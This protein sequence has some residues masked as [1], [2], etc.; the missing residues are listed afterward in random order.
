[1]M[2]LQEP[3]RSQLEAFLNY[4]TLER[5]FSGNTR[6]SYLNDLGRYL[7]WLQDAGVT[8]PEVVPGD[9]RKFIQELHDI[10]LEASSVARNV[11][12]I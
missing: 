5:N 10:G 11:S 8:P 1:M 6:V 12:A 7:S 2:E 9:I 3:H 4:L